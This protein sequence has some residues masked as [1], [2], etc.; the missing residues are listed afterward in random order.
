MQKIPKNPKKSIRFNPKK[1]PFNPNSNLPL[2]KTIEKRAAMVKSTP[3][4]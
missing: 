3:A 4:Y 1:I 2:Q